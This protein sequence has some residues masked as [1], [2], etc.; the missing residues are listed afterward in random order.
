[1]YACAYT[2]THKHTHTLQSQKMASVHIFQKQTCLHYL[3]PANLLFYLQR[4]DKVRRQARSLTR[5][6]ETGNG[7]GETLSLVASRQMRRPLRVIPSPT[8]RKTVRASR[9]SLRVSGMSV[10]REPGQCSNLVWET[11]S[12]FLISKAA[13][14]SLIIPTKLLWRE[15]LN[16]G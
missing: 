7:F 11:E 9:K 6:P 8:V 16:A 12:G 10:C 14:A 1:M 13:F 3:W 15:E 5:G 4:P 2:H